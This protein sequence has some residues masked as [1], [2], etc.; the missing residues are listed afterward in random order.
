MRSDVAKSALSVDMALEASTDQSELTNQHNPGQQIG[1]PECPVYNSS[2]E[3]TGSVPRS[4]A[5][6]AAAAGSPGGGGCTTSRP[7]SESGT[8]AGVLVA[9]AGIGI[10]RARKKRRAAK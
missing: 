7:P 2:C 10:V 3:V 4:Q 9:L 6:A 1:Q 5:Q 8:T